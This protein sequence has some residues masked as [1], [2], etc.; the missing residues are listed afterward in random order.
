[1]TMNLHSVTRNHCDPLPPEPLPTRPHPAP[2]P[3]AP[4]LIPPLIYVKEKAKWEYKQLVRNLSKEQAPTA[5]ELNTLGADGWE[6][7]STITNA[8]FVYFYFKRLVA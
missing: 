7:T 4:T 5:V 1:M 2:V 6:L 8:P 3:E